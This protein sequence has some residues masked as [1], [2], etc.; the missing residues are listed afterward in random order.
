MLKL[1][2]NGKIVDSSL[3]TNHYKLLKMDRML[4]H[5]KMVKVA[6][7][8]GKAKEEMIYGRFLICDLDSP[9]NCARE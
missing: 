5:L 8:L 1:K 4:F 7:N 2:V 9:R 3:V 6:G